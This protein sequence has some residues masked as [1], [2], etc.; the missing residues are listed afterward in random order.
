MGSSCSILAGNRARVCSRGEVGRVNELQYSSSKRTLARLA[1][2]DGMDR[3][4]TKK[5]ETETPN[6][7]DR[8]R[9]GA[10]IPNPLTFEFVPK[11]LSRYEAY[12][13]DCFSP[14]GVHILGF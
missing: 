12:G 2:K 1:G 11:G 4:K 9:G 10:P 3:R 6:N 13:H 5:L 8:A 7:R 14:K